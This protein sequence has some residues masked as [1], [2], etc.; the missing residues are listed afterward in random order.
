M[1]I[2]DTN[3]II[4]HLRRTDKGESWLR[5]ITNEVG[6]EKLAVSV[7]TIQELYAGISISDIKNEH[8]MIETIAPFEVKS[9]S[10]EVARVAGGLVRNLYGQLQFADAAIA[11]TA[12]VNGAQLATLNAKDFAGITNLELFKME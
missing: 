1:V 3:I 8:F 11:A 6:T 4:D 2:F 7:V 5:R 12:I 9:Y 10:Y